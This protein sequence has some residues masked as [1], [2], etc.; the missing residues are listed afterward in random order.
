MLFWHLL[1]HQQDYAFGWPAMPRTRI[2]RLELLA[3]AP[4]QKGRKGVRGGKSKTV[5]DAERAL[6]RQAEAAYVFP[7]LEEVP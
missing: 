3:A 7:K 5:L 2:R 1:T 4:S 6:S